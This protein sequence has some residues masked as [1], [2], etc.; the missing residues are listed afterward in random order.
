[1]T[2][3]PYIGFMS[4]QLI[5]SAALSFVAMAGFA[6]FS[7]P[8]TAHTTNGAPA[9]FGAKADAAVKLPSLGALLPSLR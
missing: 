6:L 3:W 9:L 8:V 2:I 7:A 4:K 5:L 1:M